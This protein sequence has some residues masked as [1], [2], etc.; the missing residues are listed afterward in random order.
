M[1][2][3]LAYPLLIESIAGVSPQ[4]AQQ[5]NQL[6]QNYSAIANKIN[7]LDQ[8]RNEHVQ[9]RSDYFLSPV[10]SIPNFSSPQIIRF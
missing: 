7:E 8:E 6:K 2:Q 9:V 3:W 5:F 10:S 1:L 4:V